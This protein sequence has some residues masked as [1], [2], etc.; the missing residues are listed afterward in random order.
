MEENLK[1]S[2]LTVCRLLEK[3]KVDYIIIGGAAVA[4]TGYYRHSIDI[5][6]ELTEKPDID[7]WYNPTYKNYFKIL[8]VMEDLG[9][10]ITEFK[11]EKN[12]NPRKSFFKLHFEDFTLDMLPELKAELKFIEAFKR[13]ESVQFEGTQIHFM[14]YIDLIEDKK[15]TARKKDLNDIEQLKKIRGEK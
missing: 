7:L 6:G 5:A 2:L 11:E 1:R 13:K 15:A 3:Y 9:Q 12:P 10:D 4:L 14:S 8:N